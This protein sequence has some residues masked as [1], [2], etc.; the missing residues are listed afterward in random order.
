MRTEKQISGARTYAVVDSRYDA[1]RHIF[2]Q[3]GL[4]FPTLLCV[5]VVP[6]I[7]M[8]FSDSCGFLANS[9]SWGGEGGEYITDSGMDTKE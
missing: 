4:G 2:I 3:S 6:K 9:T 5:C 1:G 8:S 7:L